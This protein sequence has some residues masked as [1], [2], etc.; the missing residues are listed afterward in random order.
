MWVPAATTGTSSRCPGRSTPFGESP[1]TTTRSSRGLADRLGRRRCV[2]RGPERLRLGRAHLRRISA[3]TRASAGDRRSGVRQVLAR[4]RGSAA[5]EPRSTTPCSPTSG[6]P[7]SPIRCRRRVAASSCRRRRSTAFGYDDCPGHPVWIE[8]DEWLGGPGGRTV[9][10]GA[11]GEP[12][13][14]PAARP[15]RRRWSQPGRKVAGREPIRIHP[16]DAAARGDRQT[17]TP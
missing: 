1:A 11:G 15:A 6:R 4:R 7:R 2:H 5:G 8:P 13:V 17:A 3:S 10:A 12:A 16:D 9:P 14:D